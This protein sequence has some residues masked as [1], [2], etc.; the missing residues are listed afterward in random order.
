MPTHGF[1][2][3][4]SEEDDMGV[5]KYIDPIKLVN[6]LKIPDGSWY[7]CGQNFESLYFKDP[8]NPL[9]TKTEFEEKKEELIK[10]KKNRIDP[11]VH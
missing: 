1:R 7:S 8:S 10:N 5:K 6:A 4:L 3:V 2:A 11:P 9:C